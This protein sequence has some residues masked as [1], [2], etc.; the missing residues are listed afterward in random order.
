MDRWTMFPENHAVLVV[1][2]ASTGLFEFCCYLGCS[3]LKNGEKVVFVENNASPENVRRQMGRFGID[4]SDHEADGTLVLVDAFKRDSHPS[5]ETA[6]IVESPSILPYIFEAITSGIDR[7]GG[8]PVR[9]ILDSLTPLYVSHDPADVWR[10]FKDISVICKANG[11][12]TSVVNK[13]ILDED[14]IAQVA[15]LADGILEMRM[16]SEYRRYVRIKHLKGTIVNPKWVPFE[17]EKDEEDEVALLGW[18]TQGEEE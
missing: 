3:Y 15:G 9:V 14:Q 11:T 16:D 1:G 5:D 13:G 12:M 2:E 6:I 7:V 4:P 8:K 18:G 10:F 17:F